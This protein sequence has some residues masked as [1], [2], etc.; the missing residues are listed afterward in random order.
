MC[1]SE[2]A[3]AQ[4]IEVIQGSRADREMIVRWQ[5]IADAVEYTV[6]VIDTTDRMMFTVTYADVFGPNDPRETTVTG[7]TSETRYIYAVYAELPDGSYS[8]VEHVI[9]TPEF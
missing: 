3:E 7:L 5:P 2:Q 8:P 6:A 9:N 4:P 1:A